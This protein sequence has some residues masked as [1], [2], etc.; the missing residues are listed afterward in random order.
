MLFVDSAAFEKE[1]V[2]VSAIDGEWN[3]EETTTKKQKGAAKREDV[4][5]TRTER[6]VEF[7]VELQRFGT[8]FAVRRGLFL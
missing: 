7:G 2:C 5:E 3:G 6:G 1:K 8:A 4:E